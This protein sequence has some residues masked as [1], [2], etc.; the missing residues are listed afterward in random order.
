MEININP[1]DWMTEKE[2]AKETL[3]IEVAETFLAYRKALADASM[4]VSDTRII[5]KLA[6]DFDLSEVVVRRICKAKGVVI[7]TSKRG[8]HA[9]A[10]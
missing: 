4:V 3:H 1:L 2:K 5:K 10:V 7:T 6:D 9:A 8:P